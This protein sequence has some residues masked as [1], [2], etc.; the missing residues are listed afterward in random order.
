MNTEKSIYEMFLP[1]DFHHHLRDGQVLSDTVQFV[2]NSFDYVLVMPNINP[3][4][5]DVNKANEYLKR[6]KDAY[7]NSH[8]KNTQPTFLMTLYLTDN[9]SS[10]DIIDVY[11]SNNVVA[12]KLYP[13]GATTNSQFGV[14]SY[15]NIKPALQ[16]MSDYQIPLLVHGEVTDPEVDI[17]DR[18]A[19][20]IENVL[21]PILLEF[22][23][24]K[25]VMEHIT[26]KQAVDF[27]TN[28]PGKNLSA[29]I[30]AH[31]LL[32]NRNAI[33]NSGICPHMYC[34]PILKREEHRLALLKAATSG[35]DK[36]FLGTDS[37]PHATGAKE[38][39]CGCAGIFTAHS[40]IELYAEAFDNIGK[41][42]MLQKFACENGRNFYGDILKKITYKPRKKITLHRES[43]IVPNYYNF[44]ELLVKPLR[45][46]EKILWKCIPLDK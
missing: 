11:N 18:E 15:D 42:D 20:F 25:V 29:T 13:S 31:H 45:S 12:L 6:I 41:L 37:A 33:F 43:W 16:T 4:V 40:A 44:G 36:F 28:Y 10:S 22:S 19:V 39:Q 2:S 27:V 34:L 21:K 32:Y 1:D 26:T 24:L 3:P 17:F 9:T 23:K 14:T 5:T 7:E 46:G 38:S 30:T 35:S 8:V